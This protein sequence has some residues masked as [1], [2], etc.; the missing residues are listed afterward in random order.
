MHLLTFGEEGYMGGDEYG[1]IAT[2]QRTN[3]ED[4]K[5]ED[6]PV[7]LSSS[8][9]A[10]KQKA[11]SRTPMSWRAREAQRLV[12]EADRL[13]A[14]AR[15]LEA[16]AAPTGP[17][18]VQGA[19]KAPQRRQA[20]PRATYKQADEYTT[21]MRE[22][23]TAASGCSC[24]S[25]R[26]HPSALSRAQSRTLALGAL[27]S[28]LNR[29]KS[30]ERPEIN[31]I[32]SSVAA[33]M[34][35]T[36]G[37]LPA[38]HTRAPPQ[39]PQSQKVIM[40]RRPAPALVD[41]SQGIPS[42]ARPSS[43]SFNREHLRRPPMAASCPKPQSAIPRRS[44]PPMRMVGG[45]LLSTVEPSDDKVVSVS[46][47]D[48]GTACRDGAIDQTDHKRSRSYPRAAPLR[49]MGRVL[50]A[51]HTYPGRV[52]PV[53][54][55]HQTTA[56]SEL[57]VA[58]TDGEALGRS[59]IVRPWLP[60]RARASAIAKLR[61]A[62]IRAQMRVAA[63]EQEAA[64][65]TAKATAERAAAQAAAREER[66]AIVRA[67]QEEEM[68]VEA[69]QTSEA[70][71]PRALAFNAVDARTFADTQTHAVTEAVQGDSSETAAILAAVD[72]ER[73]T[74]EEQTD[75][76]RTELSV[77]SNRLQVSEQQ[78]AEM[79][80][81]ILELRSQLHQVEAQRPREQ[82]SSLATQTSERRSAIWPT[83]AVQT[84][85]VLRRKELQLGAEGGGGICVLVDQLLD[86]DVFPVYEVKESHSQACA[87][88]A[89][90]P[91][92]QGA[93]ARHGAGLPAA[94][95]CTGASSAVQATAS[96]LQSVMD[97]VDDAS[98][99]AISGIVGAGS[100]V[101][102]CAREAAE[103]TV[104]AL[105][106]TM[107]AIA[108]ASRS[109]FIGYPA[110]PRTMALSRSST[111]AHA[112]EFG[113]H[114]QPSG[115]GNLRRRS[116]MRSSSASAGSQK[117]ELHDMELQLGADGGGGICVLVDELLDRD[118]SGL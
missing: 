61:L 95:G 84:Q 92:E 60:K 69:A 117:R 13:T 42:E 65:A 83:T 78:Q 25:R 64:K 36:P 30:S 29:H 18:H 59:A 100:C 11:V 19:H 17:N 45:H 90:Q 113:G 93:S 53:L 99:S 47:P 12:A 80:A 39:L 54:D 98:T 118:G 108:G 68:G 102:T 109:A 43:P 82:L 28:E 70:T 48:G 3:V 40:H 101:S 15:K 1:K 37:H 52:A 21:P 55:V 63:A 87:G 14:A 16:K 66:L 110:R 23:P 35:H 62:T 111:M 96:A 10:I 8:A 24:S 114:E 88:S 67:A 86:I 44:A 6:G 106:S 104:S 76:Q 58:R 74:A 97:A 41:P 94:R 81:E 115:A 4:E 32:N 46:W 56:T 22:P 79:A 105:G 26:D 103:A 34:Q 9:V 27:P 112:L 107:H 85:R 20:F 91:P 75:T 31:S 7:K 38:S 116:A 89:L 57:I 33:H 71:L 77:M 73:R 50:A 5:K 2:W 51:G 72:R 49:F